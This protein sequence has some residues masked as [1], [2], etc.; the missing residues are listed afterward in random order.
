M[1]AY[2]Q[3]ILI[4]ELIALVYWAVSYVNWLFFHLVGILPMPVWPSAAVALIAGLY[5]GWPIAP[6][7]AVGTILANHYLLGATWTYAACVAVMNT[8]GPL[9]AVWL[10]KRKTSAVSVTIPIRLLW[11]IAG[12]LLLAPA[13]TASGGIGSQWLLG[14]IRWEDVSGKCFAGFWH[15]PSEPFYLFLQC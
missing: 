4:N 10:V 1:K 12:G 2:R 9:I 11:L 14:M 3:I 13:L 8:L 7:L 6:A 15:I 5:W